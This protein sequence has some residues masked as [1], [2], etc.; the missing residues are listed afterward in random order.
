[1]F[2]RLLGFVERFCPRE[3]PEPAIF[4][5]LKQ[6]S[7]FIFK[8]E[9]EKLPATGRIIENLELLFMLK[10]LYELGYVTLIEEIS[11]YVKNPLTEKIMEKIEDESERKKVKQ[12]IEK[13]MMESHL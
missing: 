9:G 10:A 2:A 3:T 5:Y 12:I 11:E 6:L 7:G 13:G 1:M 8:R 4:D